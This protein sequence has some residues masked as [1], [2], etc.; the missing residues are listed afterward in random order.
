MPLV[1]QSP[2]HIPHILHH[3]P[4]DVGDGVDVVFG[5]VGEADAGHEVEVFEDGVEAFGCAG[6]EVAQGRVGVDQKDGVVGG[7]VGHVR[8]VVERFFDRH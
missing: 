3:D 6:V 1:A 8:V 2:K 7:R 5:V 4:G